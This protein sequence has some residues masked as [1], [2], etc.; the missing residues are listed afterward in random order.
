VR[1][2]STLA[3]L[4]SLTVFGREPRFHAVRL[5]YEN[6]SLH[7]EIARPAEYG[8]KQEINLDLPPTTQDY[9]VVPHF[10]RARSLHLNETISFP[11]FDFRQ[12]RVDQARAWVAKREKI[13]LPAGHFDCH[14]VEGFSGKLRWIFWIEEKLPHR[15]VK[16]VFP[17]MEI[18]LELTEWREES[19]SP[20]ETQIRNSAK[21]H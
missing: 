20:P 21:V 7:G 19:I 9:F 8:G 2:D 4:S 15:I 12:M 14:R 3:P 18:E 13:R 6:N 1:S 11:I 10:L 16:Q 5:R 17:A